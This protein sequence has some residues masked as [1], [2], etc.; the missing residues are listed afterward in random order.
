MGASTK[1]HYVGPSEKLD[2]WRSSDRQ[3]TFACNH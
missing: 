1:L 3:T 2:E